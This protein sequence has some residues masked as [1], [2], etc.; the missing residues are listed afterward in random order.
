MNI[1]LA[2]KETDTWNPSFPSN[3]DYQYSRLVRVAE[4]APP[5]EPARSPL[6]ITILI[7]AHGRKE[8]ED[9]EDDDDDDDDNDE[10][11]DDEDGRLA[12]LAKKKKKKEETNKR[13][14]DRLW[15]PRRVITTTRALSSLPRSP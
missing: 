3:L 7:T 14:E 4:P 10:D 12:K 6:P 8:D 2:Q 13:G 9:D 5:D 1:G 15:Y 11:D